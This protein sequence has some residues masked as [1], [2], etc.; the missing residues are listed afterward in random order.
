M[1]R[2]MPTMQYSSRD[3]SSV[4]E[5]ALTWVKTFKSNLVLEWHGH[6]LNIDA[7]T[8]K[9]QIMSFFDQKVCHQI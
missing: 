8:T 5:K 9:T 7:T 1:I 6:R 4:A 3:T 2:R